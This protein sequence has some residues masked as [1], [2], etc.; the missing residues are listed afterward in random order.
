[1]N[2]SKPVNS[3]RF[4]FSLLTLLGGIAVAAVGCAAMSQP[5]YLWTSLVWT[6]VTIMLAS[7]VVAAFAT[8]G[9]TRCFWASFSFFGCGYMVLTLAPWFDDHTGELIA[10]RHALDVLGRQLGYGVSDHSETTGI[11]ANFGYA[12]AQPGT[13]NGPIAPVQKTYVYYYL[14]FLIAGH[15]L[16]ALMVATGGGLLGRYCY[17]RRKE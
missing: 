2:F 4:R 11:W 7:A 3:T 10:S 14:L 5:S 16:I 17:A 8:V 6:V 13:I 9:E 1:M 12:Q 15:S